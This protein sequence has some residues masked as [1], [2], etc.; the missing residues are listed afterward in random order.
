M[1]NNSSQIASDVIEEKTFKSKNF[2]KAVLKAESFISCNFENCNFTESVWRN[3]KF[4]SCSFSNSN[5]SLVN[6]EGCRLQDVVFTECKIVGVE[7]FKCDTTFFSIKAQNSFLRY[8]NFSDL[9]MKS[10]SFQGSKCKECHFTNTVLT[11]ANFVEADLLGTIF[12]NCDLSKA[13]FTQASNYMIDPRANKIKKA[14]F[15]LPEAIELLN[16]LE[17]IIK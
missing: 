9:N 17:V 16:C 7:F 1:N 4:Y 12:H 6:L 15:S 13:D 2:S 5:I 10:T 3:V 14:K 11:E 8:C